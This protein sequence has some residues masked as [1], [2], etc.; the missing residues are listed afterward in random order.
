[1]E[2]DLHIDQ[3]ISRAYNDELEDLRRKTLVMGRLVEQQCKDALESLIQGN[4]ELAE[5]VAAS[6]QKVNDMEIEI[7]EECTE[8]LVRRQ[9]AASDL[10]LILSVIRMISDLERIGDEAEG[11]GKLA[12]KLAGNH[13]REGFHTEPHHIGQ[14]V[15]EMLHGALRAFEH[16]DVDMALEVAGRDPAINQEFEALTRLLISH[17]MEDPRDVKNVLRVNWCARA[18]ERIGDHSVN[19]C[20]YVVY[21]VKGQNVKHK[22]IDQ[23][24]KEHLA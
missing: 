2:K 12:L 21:L 24:R 6:D 1:M 15:L 18:L 4:E 16:M 19:I 11:I 20:E 3:H 10:R 8:I 7:E 23:V 14:R 13:S 5:N 17:M 9:P 22:S